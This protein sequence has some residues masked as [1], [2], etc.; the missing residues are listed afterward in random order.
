LENLLMRTGMY[1]YYTMDVD[2]E[3]AVC[4]D[5]YE[6][7]RESRIPDGPDCFDGWTPLVSH[8]I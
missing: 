1:E 8:A 6:A 4:F 3:T 2:P 5:C 7:R